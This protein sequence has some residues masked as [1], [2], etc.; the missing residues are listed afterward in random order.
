MSI[1][2]IF[3]HGD[4]DTAVRLPH[5]LR[6]DEVPA[7]AEGRDEAAEG[8]QEGEEKENQQKFVDGDTGDTELAGESTSKCS[9]E[10]LEFKVYSF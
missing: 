8:K 4:G 3:R 5:Q 2:Q 10:K 6:G 7:G 9:G 1:F